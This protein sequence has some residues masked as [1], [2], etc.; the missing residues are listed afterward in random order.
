MRG[1]IVEVE[2][3]EFSETE[4]EDLEFTPEELEAIEE[5]R[6]PDLD[7]ISVEDVAENLQAS[8][9]GFWS[10]LIT[11]VT[12]GTPR[13]RSRSRRRQEEERSRSRS[14]RRQEEERSRSRRRRQEE[15]RRLQQYQREQDDRLRR[16][17]RRQ[18]GRSSS[19]YSSLPPRYSRP[20]SY[21][22]RRQSQN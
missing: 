5:E 15:E 17:S 20:P 7:S 9:E 16:Q 11:K 6:V 8:L 3:I 21:S 10:K 12:T 14:R 19:S 22:S 1:Q 4:L 2:Q 13:R 18:S